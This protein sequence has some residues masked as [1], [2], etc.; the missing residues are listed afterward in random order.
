M[1]RKEQLKF[2]SICT[3]K[4]NSLKKGIVCSL[5][6]E[7]ATF[8][9]TCPDFIEDVEIKKDTDY[10]KNK[11]SVDYKGSAISLIVA[12]AVVYFLLP[13][14]LDKANIT[15]INPVVFQLLAAVFLIWGVFS[16]FKTIEL[17]SKDIMKSKKVILAILG[18]VLGIPLSYYFQPEMLRAKMSLLDYISE[19]N[20]I[21]EEKDLIGNVI[22]SV[23]IFTILGGI[24]GYFI[25]KNENKK[26]D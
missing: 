21:F 8:E 3:N 14:L 18:A 20:K 12:S 19:L 24:V 2:C 26:N 11:K 23:I 10:K 7:Q 6:N 16:F 4:A 1:T 13:Y 9:K 22:F 25:D 5:T 17:D 15:F